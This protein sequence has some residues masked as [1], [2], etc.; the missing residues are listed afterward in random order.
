MEQISSGVTREWL[1][2]G[3]VAA[4]TATSLG[5]HTLIDWS[6]AIISSLEKWPE[7]ADYIALHDLSTTGMSLQYLIL[8][9]Y[10]VLDP[11]LTHSGE[12]QFRDWLRGRPKT[13]VRLAVVVSSAFSGQIAMKRGRSSSSGDE[14][15]ESQLFD[16][17]EAALGWLTKSLFL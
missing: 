9:G 14:Q 1:H 17:R 10:N 8:T 4:Y 13:Q 6:K 7:D 2:D 16:N 15:F 3:K 11:W 12:A 5:M